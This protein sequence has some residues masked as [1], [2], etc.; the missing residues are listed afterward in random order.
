MVEN[1]RFY[2]VAQ[3]MPPFETLL[4][5]VPK[6]IA[7]EAT[8]IRIRAG[9]PIVI[10]TISGRYICGTRVAAIEEIY[11]CVKN[12]CNYSIHSCQRELSEG[13]LTLKGGHRAGFTGTAHI[14][15]GRI[16]TIKDISSLN[17]RIS[18][19]HKGI[20]DD[21][22]S[23][24]INSRKF[25]GLIVCGAPLS[26]K[27]TFLRDFCRN[28]GSFH[29]TALLDER[30]EIAAVYKGIPQNDIGLNT[31]VVNCFP[32]KDA[33]E[34]AVRVL[35]PEYIVCDEVGDDTKALMNCAGNGVK[36][37][38]SVHC[39]DLKEASYNR[40]ICDL[41]RMGTAN[42]ILFLGNKFSSGN[43]KGLWF[44][45]DGES[46]DSCNDSNNLLC[47]RYSNIVKNENACSSA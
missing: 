25:R 13:W 20:S 36:M 26:G 18:R 29:K 37:I 16:E 23:K 45:N 28:L 3:M 21:I 17:V 7:S 33:I 41:I 8:E 27:T 39:S 24:I 6:N 40:T 46:I 22:F 31:D 10:E 34:Q 9:K 38:L 47:G 32:K 42:Y 15:D 43:V 30:G 35:S 1:K 5:S 12:F 2:C 44:I 11:A 19:E 14:K 4:I